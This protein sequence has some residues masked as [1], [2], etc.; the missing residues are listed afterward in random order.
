MGSFVITFRNIR[1]CEKCSFAVV[2]N[3]SGLR[4]DFVFSSDESALRFYP[5]SVEFPKISFVHTVIFEI[6]KYK[7]TNTKS[8]P[9]TG[10]KN[11][12]L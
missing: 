8:M 4:Q 10:P 11:L 9:S 3:L 7:M 1:K 12:T 2:L 6:I 5:K